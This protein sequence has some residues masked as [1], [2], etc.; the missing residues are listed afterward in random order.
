MKDN[1]IYKY[2]N[3][4]K[5]DY[6]EL[7][8]SQFE[9]E[10]LKK[11]ARSNSKKKKFWPRKLIGLAA[12][13]FLS[14][15]V[16][17]AINENVRAE[18]FSYVEKFFTEVRIPLNE[19]KGVPKEI[20]KYAVNL[21][22][23]VQLKNA[24]FLIEDIMVDGKNGYLNIIYPEKYLNT[25]NNELYSIE[26]VY[27]NGKAKTVTSSGSHPVKI[28]NGLISDMREFTLSEPMPNDGNLNLIIEFSNF[29]DPKDVGAV[30][31]NLSMKDLNKDSKL[32]LQDF[33]IPDSNGYKIKMMK[34]NLINPRIEMIEPVPK[35]NI[36]SFSEIIGKNQEGKTLVFHITQGNTIDREFKTVYKFIPK[37]SE[38]DEKTSDISI[39][40]INSL[41]GEFEFQMYKTTLEQDSKGKIINKKTEKIGKSFVVNFENNITP[42]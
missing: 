9:I 17:V 1:N 5:T 14:F 6:E 36:N 7:E 15:G 26:K 29:N 11:F 32:Y 35:G 42:Q 37:N 27:V 39:K 28:E 10:K 33:E 4:V 38:F 23:I 41:K 2:L 31:V 25:K 30:E 19:A 13:I 18:V 20:E 24:S 40:D 8:L 21:H 22:E 34:I 16:L 12:S 3:D